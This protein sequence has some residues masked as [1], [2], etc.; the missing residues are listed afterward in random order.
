M[1]TLKSFI[2]N[3]SFLG[4]AG[5][6]KRFIEGFLKLALPL[7]RLT[8]KGQTYVWSVQCEEIFQELK[9][10]LTSTPI[11]IFP[12]PSESFVVYRDASEMGLGGVLMQNGQIVAYASR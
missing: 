5:Y 3:I 4:L 9:K 1:E 11:L 10:K 7:T 2:D 12:S 8:R 6:Y